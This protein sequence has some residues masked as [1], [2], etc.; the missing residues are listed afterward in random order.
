M[1][2][3][4]CKACEEEP[5]AKLPNGK[6]GTMCE[7]CQRD[8]DENMGKAPQTRFCHTCSTNKPVEEFIG[9]SRLCA[10]CRAKAPVK[11]EKRLTCSVCNEEKN[12][13]D[14][15]RQ[16][17]YA[18]PVCKDC[19]A[20]KSDADHSAARLLL[21]DRGRGQVLHC[22]VLSEIPEGASR[23]ERLIEFYERQ[24]CRV[25]DVVERVPEVTRDGQPFRSEIAYETGS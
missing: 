9:A 5:R 10:D 12:I 4:L 19:Y 15:S 7:G 13:T 2:T 8:Y 17:R 6:L 25:I 20:A 21:V 24:G 16:G 3:L 22:Q 23:L 18:R 14:F 1:P 11:I